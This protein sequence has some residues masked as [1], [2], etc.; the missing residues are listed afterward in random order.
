MADTDETMRVARLAKHSREF[1]EHVPHNRALGIRID[2]LADGEAVMTLPYSAKLVG[3]PELGVL[4]GGAITSMMDACCGAAAFMKVVEAV[5]IATLDLRIDYLKPATAGRDVVAR[6]NCYRRTRNIAFVRCVAY[7]DQE[8]EP[9]AA[10]VGTF[11]LSAVPGRPA[12]HLPADAPHDG[13]TTDRTEG[14]S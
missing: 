2:R 6:A 13:G 7:H 5:P 10:A 4:H 11:M 14:R 1:M 3:N 12:P 9:I 8:D